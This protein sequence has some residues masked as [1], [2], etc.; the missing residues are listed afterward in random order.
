[1][2][3]CFVNIT[4]GNIVWLGF[5]FENGRTILLHPQAPVGHCQRPGQRMKV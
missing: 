3:A 1:M 5:R 2:S 4:R